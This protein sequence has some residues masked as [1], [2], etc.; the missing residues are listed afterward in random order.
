MIGWRV[1]AFGCAAGT[2]LLSAALATRFEPPA[3]GPL[4]TPSVS[5]AMTT[6]GGSG[7]P[8]GTA[9]QT[10]PSTS[11]SA[12]SPTSEGLP[13]QFY[14]IERAVRD[15]D[16]GTEVVVT[17]VARNLPW[18]A[19][20]H[21]DEVAFELVAVEMRWTAS[22]TYTVPMRWVDFSIAS[23]SQFPNR[24][25]SV[26]DDK[27]RADGWVLLPTTL[28]P[29]TT[30]TGWIVFKVDP[31]AATTLRLDYTRPALRVTNQGLEFPRQVFSIAL[32][33]PALD[34]PVFT[35][36]PSPTPSASTST[37]SGSSAQSASPTNTGSLTSTT[38]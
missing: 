8:T 38:P 6:I 12:S 31:R 32:A 27:L 36:I 22:G 15:P 18:P 35:A 4:S 1:L 2:V 33:D 28:A 34:D 9:E 17:R 20:R 24:P 16:I 7:S 14:G 37:A 25:D 5:I 21:G 19:G 30:A 10:Q 29:G 3:P 26:L 23:S 13:S 11:A